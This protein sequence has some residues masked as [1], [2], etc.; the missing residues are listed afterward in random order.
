MFFVI[1]KTILAFILPPASL[2]ILL[3]LG[4]VIM[5]KR[6]STGLA[7][8]WTCLALLYAVSTKP[9][10]NGLM[11]RL[12]REYVP[13][14]PSG[15]KPEAVV[16]LS[17]GVRDLSWAGLGQA[18]S[19]TSLS[20]TVMGV[21]LSRAWIGMPMVF[22]GGNGDP[23]KTGVSEAQAMAET[24]VTLGVRKDGIL[25]EG[26]SRNTLESA[27]AVAGIIRERRIVLMTSAFHMRRSVRM[28]E[29]QGFTVTP[30][31]VAYLTEQAPITLWSFIPSAA[32]M[33][34]SA[35][36]MQEYGSRA[37]YSLIGKI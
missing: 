33:C 16:V 37:W 28:F 14:T 25:V 8:I 34:L 13:Y 24:A 31:P 30:A 21:V 7:I 20:R 23:A 12:E 19:E 10:A 27:V 2:L 6:R 35:A 26:T 1:S 5:K 18:P 29:K 11:N 3:V 22:S 32:S 15:K 36:A 4:L 17:G 9:V